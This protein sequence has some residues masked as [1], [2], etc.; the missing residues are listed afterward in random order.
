MYA[1]PNGGQKM[2]RRNSSMYL[3]AGG[4]GWRIINSAAMLAK[5]RDVVSGI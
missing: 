2:Y 4:S 3:R 5:W 1:A